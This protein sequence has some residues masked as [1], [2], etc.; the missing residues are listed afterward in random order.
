MKTEKKTK[1]KVQIA[2]G[3]PIADASTMKAK[4]AHSIGCAIIRSNGLIVDFILKVSCDV[5]AN[6]TAMVKEAIERGNTH[7]LFVDS[8]MYFPS[9]A[10]LKLLAHNKDIVGVEY[11]KRKFPLE[12]AVD[13]GEHQ[14]TLYQAKAVGTGL[15]LIKLSIFEK[16]KDDVWFNFGRNAEGETVMGEDVWFCNVAWDAGFEVWCDPTIKTGHIGEYIY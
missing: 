12:L 2:I 3:L 7:I 13:T 15:L 5:V 10:V 4:T 11:N 6:R 16:M 14:D 9:D 8:D 1:K